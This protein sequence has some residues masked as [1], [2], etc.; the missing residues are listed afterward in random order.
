MS[1]KYTWCT[2]P[3]H[4]LSLILW[5]TS[6]SISPSLWIIDPRYQKL[7]LFSISWPSSLTV[8]LYMFWLLLNL[9]SMYFVLVRINRKPLD[10]WAFRQIS[11]LTLTSLL[12]SSI[13]TISSA[14]NVHQGTSSWINLIRSSIT[15]AKSYGLKEDPWCKPK[16]RLNFL[17]SAHCLEWFK[18]ELAHKVWG[19]F[20]FD[21]LHFKIFIWII[22]VWF[23]FLFG[24]L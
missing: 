12:V 5:F 6:F 15:S 11:N 9:H 8:P 10:S 13:K 7:S 17:I 14:K 20:Y 19:W 18:F 2:S 4:L 24:P 1:V 23:S 22:H 16:D 3:L 21:P